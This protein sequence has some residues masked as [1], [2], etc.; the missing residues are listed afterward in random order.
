MAKQ[1]EKALTDAVKSRKRILGTKQIISA[2]KDS[3]LVVISNSVP[4]V[5]AKKIEENAKSNNVP[6]VHFHDT[7]VILGKLCGL[8][9]RVSAISLSSLSSTNVQ[10]ILKEYEKK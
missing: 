2:I 4:T 9:F 10:A 5:S 6:F 7:S 8:P 1:L 3:K